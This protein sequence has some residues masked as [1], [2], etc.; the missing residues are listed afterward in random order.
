[1]EP[2]R[3]SHDYF[4]IREEFHIFLSDAESV[5]SPSCRTSL[6]LQYLPF[7]LSPSYHNIS[8]KIGWRTLKI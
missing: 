5:N 1:M 6:T 7:I 4:R 2:N 8:L 3:F